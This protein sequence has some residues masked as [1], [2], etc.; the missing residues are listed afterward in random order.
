MNSSRTF[1]RPVALAALALST[2]VPLSA[3]SLSAAER[4]VKA[5]ETV[6]KNDALRRDGQSASDL[7]GATVKTPQNEKVGKVEDFFIDLTS[8]KIVGVILSSGGF[9]G[10]GDDLSVVQPSSLSRVDDNELRLD[11]T[12]EKLAAAPRY[13]KRD[14][15]TRI[16]DRWSNTKD[17]LRDRRDA[18]VSVRESDNRRVHDADNTA[19]NRRDREPSLTVDPLDQSN[20]RSDIE[21]TAKIRSALV[22]NDRLSTNAKN[23]KIITRDGQV[24]LRGPVDSDE[25][26]RA[27]A[28]A[29]AQAAPGRVSNQIEVTAR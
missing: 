10:L 6:T 20:K 1:S 27:V 25:E 15:R 22:A 7:I 2:L 28:E 29:A 23:V 11:M 13:D 14:L 5:D 3:A 19:R 24:T 12:R 9:L 18:D 17:D 21:T 16:Q 4:G 8:G 26:K